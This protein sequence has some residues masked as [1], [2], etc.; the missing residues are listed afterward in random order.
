MDIRGRWA[1]ITGASAGIGRDL[2]RELA[3]RGTNCLLVARRADRLEELAREIRDAGGDCRVHPVDLSDLASCDSVVKDILA[4]HD[5]IDVLVNNAGRSIRRS[6]IHSTE[7]FHDFERTMEINYFAAVRLIMGFLPSMRAARKGHI[8]N[9]SSVGS[10]VVPPR[11]AAYAAS[12]SALDAFSKSLSAEVL[13]DGIHVTTVYMP[14]VRT[15]MISP[16]RLYDMAPA[17]SPSEAADLV[18]HALLTRPKT[19]A[20][21]IGTAGAILQSVFPRLTDRIQNAIYR[22]MPESA[23]A[24]GLPKGEEEKIRGEAV[25][26]SN[27]L[28]GIHL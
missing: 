20:T 3:A 24:T 19:V 9:I 25:L 4:E 8:V 7:R 17:L 15:E 2:A 6:L 22:I 28:K 23:A 16:T 21:K 26:L 14:L 10:Q 11:F 5:A 27:L 13:S 1:L 12:K 18:V